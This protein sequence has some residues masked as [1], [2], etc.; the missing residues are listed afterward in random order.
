MRFFLFLFYLIWNKKKGKIYT[1]VDCIL[2]KKKENTV[3]NKQ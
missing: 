3:I 1:R 2:K